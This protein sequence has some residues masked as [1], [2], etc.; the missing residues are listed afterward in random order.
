MET[1]ITRPKLRPLDVQRL[2]Q[3]GQSYLRLRDPIGLG[4]Q[5]VL[6]PLTLAPLLSLCDGTRDL[7]SLRTALLLL[8]GISP[9]LSQMESI[10]Q[11]LDEALLLEGFRFQE[12]YRQALNSYHSAPYRPP[13]LAG[14]GYPADPAALE[15]MLADYCA[16]SPPDAEEIDGKAA[17]ILG[18]LSP[19]IDY[20]RGHQVYAKTW[21]RIRPALEECELVILLGTD[22]A[23]GA[24]R[25]T[26]TRQHYATPWGTVPTDLELVE[27]LIDGLGE[28]A[29][30]AEELHHVREHSIELA[31]VWLHYLLRNIR[32][33]GTLSDG[34]PRLLPILCGH[35]EPFLQGEHEPEDDPAFQHLIETLYGVMQSRKTL[36]VAAGDLAH[37]GPAF[38]DRLPR[39]VVDRAQ[40]HAKDHQSLEAVC[41]GDAAT[42]FQDL[43]LDGGRRRICGLAPIYLAL[44]LLCDKIVGELTDYAQCPA[45]PQGSSLVSI[46][47]VVWRSSL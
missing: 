1:T 16:G 29:A 13:A 32:D 40:L 34:L 10:V 18:L 27:S 5:E 35:M 12:A 8:Q 14:P 11:E 6:I 38:G 37:V 17:P 19:H 31:V 2:S 36:V 23:G 30:L 4:G 24:G 25:I 22:H 43:R 47:G 42:F 28:D 3:G 33:R 41:R 21:R 26:P 45:D 39:T 15:R 7:A 9:S 44:R 20:Q 46:A